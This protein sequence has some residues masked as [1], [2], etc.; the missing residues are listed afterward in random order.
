M[1]RPARPARGGVE[2]RATS[3]SRRAPRRHAADGAR[4]PRSGPS[5]FNA[6]VAGF[7]LLVLSQTSRESL[8]AG[9]SATRPA[10]L[11]NTKGCG[12]GRILAALPRRF[13]RLDDTVAKNNTRYRT[14]AATQATLQPLHLHPHHRG[15]A[16]PH[17]DPALAQLRDAAAPPDPA[18]ARAA[19]PR[20]APGGAARRAGR[21]G[22]GARRGRGGAR[23]RGRRHEAAD[24]RGRGG[25]RGAGGGRNAGGRGRGGRA[26]RGRSR[27]R[28]GGGSRRARGRR[29]AGS[30]SGARGQSSRRARGRRGPS[31]RRAAR[32][33]GRGAHRRVVP[34]RLLV[35]TRR[36]FF[37]GGGSST[38]GSRRWRDVGHASAFR[39]RIA[40][41]A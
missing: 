22:G 27:G 18:A 4:A 3:T 9:G 41:M 29:R 15:R 36:P 35:A 8:K 12:A 26:A 2:G 39:E 7:L 33:R 5:K 6:A 40:A 10:A 14:N 24:G 17:D 13:T 34:R 16:A 21:G 23:R 28:A 38:G 25:A 31:S 19:R 37:V 32:G 30:G 11:K 1:A 20:L